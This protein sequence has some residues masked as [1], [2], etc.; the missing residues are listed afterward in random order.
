VPRR[1]RPT[2]LDALRVL[3]ELAYTLELYRRRGHSLSEVWVPVAWFERMGTAP[4]DMGQC[5]QVGAA[6]RHLERQ[7][8]TISSQEGRKATVWSVTAQ[9]CQE[10]ERR[11]AERQPPCCR[12]CWQQPAYTGDIPPVPTRNSS[13]AWTEYR[14]LDCL[15]DEVR[16]RRD[17]EAT[18]LEAVQALAA[19]MA[20]WAE[21]VLAIPGI[22]PEEPQP[23][24]AS[25]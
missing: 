25:E 13:Q 7:G 10:L 5:L 2:P 12:K 3:S 16:R 17:R 15:G 22:P 1:S 11:Q 6:L 24:E 21:Q 18:E 9:G 19:R 8:M 23:T 20:T 4:T 14:C